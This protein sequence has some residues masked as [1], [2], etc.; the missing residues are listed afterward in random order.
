V[1]LEFLEF[2]LTQPAAHKA[3]EQLPQRFE[4]E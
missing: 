1:R 4:L 2:V 3:A